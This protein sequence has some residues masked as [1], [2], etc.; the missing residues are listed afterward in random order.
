MDILMV[1]HSRSGKTSYMAGLYKLFGNKPEGFGI[2][3][4]DSDK[5][6][7]LKLIGDNVVRG[8]YPN[9]TDIASEYCFWLQ[10]DNSLLIPFNWYDYRGGALSESSKQSPEAAQLVR[11]IDE[12]DALIVFLDGGKITKM[13]DYDLKSEYDILI[14]SIL[15]SISKKSSNGT[16]FP[17][18]FVITKGDLYSNENILYDSKGFKYFIPVITNIAKSSVSVGMIGIVKVSKKGISNVFAPLIFSL[19]YG[20]HHYIDERIKSIDATIARCNNLDPS[21]FDDVFSFIFGCKSDRES[22]EDAIQTIK[23]EKEDL[24]KLSALSDVMYTKLNYFVK[25]RKIKII[26]S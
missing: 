10:Y 6:Q 20:M 8:I 25:N 21:L 3:I 11:K 1:G 13:T 12:A 4:F 5:S 23:E 18:S 2:R 15:K 26:K 19:Y 24:N 7:N 17:V 9:G 14:W 22:V 16:Y